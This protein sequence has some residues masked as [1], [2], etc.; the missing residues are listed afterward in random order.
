MH[1]HLLIPLFD[2]SDINITFNF[3]S[4]DESFI[5]CNN[6]SSLILN[7]YTISIYYLNLMTWV[8]III[9]ILDHILFVHGTSKLLKRIFPNIRI[10]TCTLLT[11]KYVTTQYNVPIS[12]CRR[13]KYKFLS[14]LLA[15]RIE[16]LLQNLKRISKRWK[17]ELYMC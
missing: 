12:K 4:M 3:S 8:N 9:Y 15:S 11:I 7:K 5:H 2:N 10:G 6:F 1:N 17:T 16:K 13:K 14:L